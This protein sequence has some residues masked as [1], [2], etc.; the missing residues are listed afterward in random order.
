MKYP[1]MRNEL[2]SY[3]EGLSDWEYQKKCWI[4]NECPNKVENDELD[5][6]VHF[7]FDDTKLSSN[8]ESLIG[9]FLKNKIEAQAVKSVCEE[10][11]KIFK[12]YGYDRSDKEYINFSEW[13]K[14][15]KSASKAF[16]LLM[17]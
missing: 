2:I 11:D 17:G 6:A 5:Y 14:V 15:I 10:L 8:P 1:N 3:L 9:I 7:L 4:L 13:P 12:K 16:S